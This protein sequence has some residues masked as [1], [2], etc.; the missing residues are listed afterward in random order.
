MVDF[1][2]VTAA[3]GVVRQV[4]AHHQDLMVVSFNFEKSAIGDKH[5]HVHVQSTY[6]K[7]GKFRFFLD[8][9]EFTVCAGD[10]FVIPSN[11]VHG[12]EC[13]EAG[14]LIDCFTPCRKDFL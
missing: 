14:E 8:D 7:S 6:V 13:L 4:L 12:C 5:N 11:A 9:Q 3:Q 1:P 2:R 10:S